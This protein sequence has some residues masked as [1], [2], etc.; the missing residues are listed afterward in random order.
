LLT[1][2]SHIS[3]DVNPASSHVTS[4]VLP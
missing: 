2:I 1:V 3:R 4:F